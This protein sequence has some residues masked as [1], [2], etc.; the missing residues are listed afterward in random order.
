MTF[1]PRPGDQCPRNGAIPIPDP[2]DSFCRCLVQ[3]KN[4]NCRDRCTSSSKEKFDPSKCPNP[5]APVTKP[6]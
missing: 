2:F 4:K 1:K 5:L 3:C 6:T